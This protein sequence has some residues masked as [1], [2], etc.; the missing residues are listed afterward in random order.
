MKIKTTLLFLILVCSISLPIWAADPI[1][2]DHPFNTGG[3]NASVMQDRDGFIWVG[4]TNGIVR[5]DGYDIKTYGAGPGMLSSSYAPGIFE[6]DQGVFW[7]GT[8]GG[9][10]NRFDKTTQ[11]FTA[12]RTD[13]QDP[14]SISSDQFNWAPKTIGQDSRG[15]LWIGT[16]NGLNRLD[17]KSQ[18]FERF[19]HAKSNAN[20]ISHDSIWTVFV[21]ERD[22]VWIGTETGLDAY[23]P[24]TG[25]FKRYVHD[26]KDATTIG[27]GRVY[28]IH[29]QGDNV[30]W[31]GTSHG[32]LN[33]FD[34]T[35][36]RFK[37]FVH[38]EE[39]SSSLSHNEVFSIAGD[40]NGNLW[41]GR[42]YSVAAGLEIF[43][44]EKGTSQRYH[45]APNNEDSLSG[46]I[47]MGCFKDRSGIMWVIENTGPVDKYDPNLKLFNT[48][49]HRPGDDNSLS[50]NAVVTITQDHSGDIWLATQLGGL[51]RLDKNGRFTAFKWDPDIPQG[52]SDNYVFSVLE[53]SEKLLW[54]S[55]NDG[56]HGVFNPDSGIFIKSYKNPIAT[57]AARGMI[58]DR[59]DTDLLWFGTEADGLFRFNKKTGRFK[60]F[61][62][63]PSRPGSLSA[64]TVLSLFQD[65]QGVLWVPTHGGGLNRYD[66]KQEKFVTYRA[67]PGTQGSISGDMVTDC[68]I[69]Y[70]GHFWVATSDGGLNLFDRHKGEFT[71]FT[72]GRGFKTRSIR[73]ILEDD[74]KHLWLSTDTGLVKFSLETQRVVADYSKSDGLQGDNFSLYS[75]SAYK[76]RDGQMWFAGLKGVT[77][78]YPQKIKKNGNVPSIV[79]TSLKQDEIHLSIPVSLDWQHN[80]FE[81]EF[82]ALNF[83]QP[84]KNRYAYFLEGFETRKNYLAN[85]RWGKYTNLPGGQYTLKLFGANN[86]GVWNEKGISIPIFVETE[87]W[88]TWWAAFLYLILG[89]VGMA[90]FFRWQTRKY[91]IQLTKERRVSE[92]LRFIDNMR[93]DLIGKQKIVE[94]ELVKSKE[95][96]E[97]LVEKRTHQLRE[98]KENA[99]AADQ[100][101][102]QFL[103]NMSHE[104]RTPLNLI[105]GFS[106]AL[107]KEIT[108]EMHKEYLNSIRS[109]GK[110]L[111]T[112]F[113]DVLDLSR[114]E[115]GKFSVDYQAF[116]LRQ[117][118]SQIRLMFAQ[119][120]IQKSIGWELIIGDNV[121]KLI[122][123]DEIRFRQILVNIIGNAI[124]FTD[125]GH[126]KITVNLK[127]DAAEGELVVI[128]EDTGI[129][130]AE[131][132]LDHVFDVFYQQKGQNHNKY[133]GTGL[134]LAISQR[135]AQM[136]NGTI[137]VS[138][139]PGQGTVFTIRI[140]GV[141]VA[142]DDIRRKKVVKGLPVSKN[143]MYGVMTKQTLEQL[144]GL[145][146]EL[147]RLKEDVW[148]DLMDAM[149]ID[150]IKRFAGTL[151]ELSAVFQYQHLEQYADQLADQA[152][153]FDMVRLPDTLNR[154]P[155]IEQAVSNIIK[156]QAE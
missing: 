119:S 43:N 153:K 122:I 134:G 116:D 91:E 55:M 54:V 32:G 49:F 50:A 123:F 78:F 61:K 44:P 151:K 152:E 13:L 27:R 125:Q 99:E 110:T 21:D 150:D 42:S 138:S 68:L 34:K 59:V 36:G 94:K 129:G 3:Y 28:A 102:S 12:F 45:H 6:D 52:I 62:A 93:S 100:A 69:D 66:K 57:V 97:E 17:K 121:P 156:S 132:E 29:S 39:N 73:A 18:V 41:L 108:N 4:C 128:V 113:N 37:R 146:E 23:D 127:G 1:I 81:F 11:A 14:Y 131:D 145:Y 92:Q 48:Y 139:V 115:A 112:L 137:L 46:N 76:T 26:P 117:M 8:V 25:H 85:R 10:L 140:K 98:A 74:E 148:M 24:A 95:D 20:S 105:L 86:D 84:G 147:I 67:A 22:I 65:P 31:I 155:E 51:N 107:E 124:K 118:F 71:H 142:S 47:I 2:F 104:I 5:Y 126:V 56:V 35:T 63:D 149:V 103:A 144:D 79:L 106:Q 33:R 154:F 77:S 96:L 109:S 88:K 136:L 19:M 101:K 60:Q 82:V 80:F 64:N 53:D 111:L 70:K 58:Q 90:V 72:K 143:K 130:I 40:G 30:L 133:G 75:S 114:I 87:P 9:G 15:N 7:I 16:R 135:L 120:I 141:K 83:T 38:K 89:C